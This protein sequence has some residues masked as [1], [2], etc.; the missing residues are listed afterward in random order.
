MGYGLQRLEVLARAVRAY[1]FIFKKIS[2]KCQHNV[3]GGLLYTCLDDIP[4]GTH[5]FCVFLLSGAAMH[6]Q[7]RAASSFQHLCIGNGLLQL[8]EHP[9]LACHWYFQ[10][11]HC[12]KA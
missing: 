7:H 3:A 5:C 8:R 10:T 12:T 1:D 4:V 6:C 11:L 9:Y 2:C